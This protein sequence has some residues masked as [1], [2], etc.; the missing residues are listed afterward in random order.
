MGDCQVE[1][2]ARSMCFQAE[3]YVRDDRAKELTSS[4]TILL[5]QKR[6]QHGFSRAALCPKD[7]ETPL[8][9]LKMSKNSGTKQFHKK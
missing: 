2:L 8:K 3:A 1:R 6:L 4:S 7:A 5:E 9:L